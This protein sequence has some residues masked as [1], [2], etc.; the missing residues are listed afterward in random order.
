MEVQVEQLDGVHKKVTVEVPEET[1]KEE[2]NSVLKDLKNRVRIKGFRPGKVPISIIE[3]MYKDYVQEQVANNIIKATLPKALEENNIEPLAE[4][5]IE[6]LFPAEKGKRFSYSVNIE[7]IPDIELKEYKGIEIKTIDVD[8][9]D[10]M[11]DKRIE[12]I[13]LSRAELRP[14]TE[15]RAAREKDIVIVDYVT[16]VDG[17]ELDKGNVKNHL[18]ELGKGRFHPDFEKEIIGLSVGEEKEF[19]I[20]FPEDFS[21]KELAGKDVTFKV[22]LNEI[23]EKVLPELTDEFA[24]E[25]SEEISSVEELR[26]KVREEIEKEIK[27]RKKDHETREVIKKLI[28]MHEI[29][30]PPSMVE[31]AIQIRLNELETMLRQKGYSLSSSSIDM[32][33]LKASLKSEVEEQVKGRLILEAIAEKE[34]V[35][36]TDEDIDREMEEVSKRTG[37]AKDV[38]KQIY[39]SSN[40]S[41]LSDLKDRLRREKA[42]SI[43]ID[44][45]TITIDN[46]I[47]K[48]SNE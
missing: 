11:V 41:M 28:D 46:S 39:S 33:E 6:S 26:T 4:P 14:I 12:E 22:K 2:F 36:V 8:V 27:E 9:T 48:N 24:K 5:S 17:K 29:E 18:I 1:V 45:A 47:D 10:E 40:T 32:E 13:R 38:I 3:G 23:K 21:N 30:A 37:Q 44:H 43:I 34:G 25:V 7:V 35:E 42:L 15:D 16:I 19:T 20:S 31:R